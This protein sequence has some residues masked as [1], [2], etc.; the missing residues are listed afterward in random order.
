[1]SWIDNSNNENNFV[2][3]RSLDGGAATEIATVNRSS[4]ARTQTGR[5]VSYT[6]NSNLVTGAYTYYVIANKTSAPIAASAQSNTATANFVLPAI[7]A[8]PSN[9][10]VTMV[11]AGSTDTASL[12]WTD[13][14]DNET[15]FTIQRATDSAFTANLNSVTVGANVTTLTQTNL[16]RTTGGRRNQ[17]AITYYYQIQAMNGTV[18]SAWNTATGV[19]AP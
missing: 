9:L 3:W 5:T 4:N 11:N 1:L 15:G 6:D 13:N 12:T 19:T 16:A 2:I 10:T 14:S 17:T 7:P 18:V 8:A